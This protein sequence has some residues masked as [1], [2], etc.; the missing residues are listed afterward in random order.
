MPEPAVP[1]PPANDDDALHEPAFY[2]W[3]LDGRT[4]IKP[5]N[6]EAAELGPADEATEI[7]AAYLAQRNSRDRPLEE[8]WSPEDF[9]PIY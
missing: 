2:L 5:L 7:F 3:E 6:G 1:N 8:R 4:W 9:S